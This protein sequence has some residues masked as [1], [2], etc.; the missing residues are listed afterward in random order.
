MAD[1]IAIGYDDNTT[2]VDALSQFGGTVLKS[3]L[4]KDAE[5]EL[6]TALHGEPGGG[7]AEPSRT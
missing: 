7:V 3:S 1:L 5:Q 6:Q 2:A 4:S